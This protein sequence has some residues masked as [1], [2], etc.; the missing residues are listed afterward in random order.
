MERKREATGDGRFQLT[1][2]LMRTYM[3]PSQKLVR[4]PYLSRLFGKIQLT[5][6]YAHHLP[7][8]LRGLSA[9]RD[10]GSDVGLGER[11][12]VFKVRLAGLM[13]NVCLRV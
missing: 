7:L 3:K 5:Q 10:E 4:S 12:I 9:S 6:D 2:L 13:F 8:G 1:V 11:G